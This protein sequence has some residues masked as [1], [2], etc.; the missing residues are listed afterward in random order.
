L[1]AQQLSKRVVGF[2]FSEF[3]RQIVSNASFG[4]DH[5]TA[6]PMFI[7]GDCVNPEIIGD[8]V[9][10]SDAQPKDGVPMQF[11]FRSVYGSVLMDW[12]DVDKEV[13]NDILFNE[14]QHL[15]IINGCEIDSSA[16]IKD[17]AE[18]NFNIMPNPI[19]D[20]AEIRFTLAKADYVNIRILDTLGGEH[21]VLVQKELNKGNHKIYLDA[22][23]LAIG[24]Y[25]CRI[26]IGN[27]QWSRKFVKI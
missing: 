6:A 8:N 27:R 22:D 19:I 5:G 7:F 10:V 13:I 25:Y 15:P 11:D 12:F 17:E 2:T 16:S 1:K 18:L 4:T 20:N 3:G 9:D 21:F 26:A 24:V 14:F 23:K